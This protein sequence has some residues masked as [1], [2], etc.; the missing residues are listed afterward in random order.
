MRR[1]QRFVPEPSQDEGIRSAVVGTLGSHG[2]E[3][4]AIDLLVQLLDDPSPQVR[5]PALSSLGFLRRPST[6]RKICSLANDDSPRVRAWVAIALGNFSSLELAELGVSAVLDQLAAD[7]DPYVRDEAAA[8]RRRKP[9]S[10]P[11]VE[12]VLGEAD[13]GGS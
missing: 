1:E 12:S 5:I 7:A 13:L 10:S 3:P 8:A 9:S 11:P 2:T 6:L 4:A